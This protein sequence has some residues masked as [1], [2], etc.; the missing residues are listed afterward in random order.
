MSYEDLSHTMELLEKF[1]SAVVS[2]H[3]LKI[4]SHQ[5]SP[6]SPLHTKL[7]FYVTKL[8]DV[9]LLFPILLFIFHHSGC[10][11]PNQHNIKFEI[12][13]EV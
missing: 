1:N 2:A 9:I 12:A 13:E 11:H 3:V 8:K 7:K 4:V 5:S 6:L 10:S